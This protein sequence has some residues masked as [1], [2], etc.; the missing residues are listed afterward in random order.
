M[1]AWVGRACNYLEV[2]YVTLRWLDVALI[3]EVGKSH[4]RFA[5]SGRGFCVGGGEG[6]SARECTGIIERC[7]RV[8]C[9]RVRVWIAL[10]G[11]ENR[12]R[13]TESLRIRMIPF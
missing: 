3:V 5:W 4:G 6:E 8:L 10:R 1:A 7:D 9:V 12:L 2:L 11:I 13:E